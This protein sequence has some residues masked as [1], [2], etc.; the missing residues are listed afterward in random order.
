MKQTARLELVGLSLIAGIMVILTLS[1]QS[2]MA[3]SQIPTTNCAVSF[4][5]SLYS[6]QMSPAGGWKLTSASCSVTSQS[7]GITT[8]TF[9]GNFASTLNS[10]MVTGTWSV[11]GST[12]KVTA[13]ST[14]FSVS[15]SVAE[16]VDQVPVLGSSLQG[17][18]SGTGSPTML[19]AGI[20][21]Q[22]TIGQ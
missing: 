9:T 16:G 17:M 21:G 14:D 12:Q 8:G 4:N 19:A 20:T 22:I 5:G 15:F 1:G 18:F 10:G 11:A 6:L 7:G 3:T 2:T 13:S